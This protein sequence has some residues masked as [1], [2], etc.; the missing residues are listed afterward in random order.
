MLPRL[1]NPFEENKDGH[2]KRSN[3]N[4][5]ISAGFGSFAPDVSSYSD[6]YPS[7]PSSWSSTSRMGDSDEEDFRYPSDYEQD[8]DSSV[9]VS[10][11]DYL[12]DQSNSRSAFQNGLGSGSSVASSSHSSSSGIVVKN[13]TLKATINTVYVS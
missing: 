6:R 3:S 8:D 5:P 12:V 2:R 13:I 10:H 9:P 4:V 1:P 11:P 7:Q